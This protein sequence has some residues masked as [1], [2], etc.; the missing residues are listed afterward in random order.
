MEYLLKNLY[1]DPRKQCHKFI[2]ENIETFNFVNSGNPPEIKPMYKLSQPNK[3]K[4]L[5][6]EIKR[7][8]DNEDVKKEIEK[9][10]KN[11]TKNISQVIE[12]LIWRYYCFCNPDI[13]LMVLLDKTYKK[14]S[15]YEFKIK[16][17]EKQLKYITLQL[18]F[19]KNGFD[20]FISYI[21]DNVDEY[22]KVKVLPFDDNVQ[23]KTIS[24]NIYLIEKLDKFNESIFFISKNFYELVESSKIFLNYNNYDI[25]EK[26][27]SL[28]YGANFVESIRTFFRL[29]FLKIYL[30][31]N[32]S[33][34]DQEYAVLSG[35][36]LLFSLGLRFSRDTDIFCIESKYTNPLSLEKIK[37]SFDIKIFTSTNTEYNTWS[38]IVLYPND[39]NI[40]FGFKTN[41]IKIESY[42]RYGRYLSINSQ[43]ALG[44]LLVIKYL[45]KNK[46]YVDFNKI[47]N[48]DR[49][50]HYRYRNLDHLA[51]KK[52]FITEKNS[53]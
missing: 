3:F 32:Y 14:K 18:N 25:F 9:V 8:I 53:K 49:L 41:D 16:I 10:E 45:M 23:E 36:F 27:F 13:R 17:S 33:L 15:L 19:M 47:K 11:G 6:K 1:G 42:K 37:C 52:Y 51:I 29:K 43:K 48:I 12:L 28:I 38:K 7:T 24:L 44:D 46:A 31:Q 4:S 35:S 21:F 26:Q 34:L 22:K 2:H 5:L 20:E 50:L 40:L 30:H 39:Y